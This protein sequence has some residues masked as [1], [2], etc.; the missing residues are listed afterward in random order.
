MDA[1]LKGKSMHV[2]ARSDEAI[3]AVTFDWIASLRLQ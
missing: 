2:I 3:H 1:T